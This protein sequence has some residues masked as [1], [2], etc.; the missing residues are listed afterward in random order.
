MNIKNF[1]NDSLHFYANL[2]ASGE[3]L[4]M[5]ISRKDAAGGLDLYV[6][7]L[8]EKTREWSSPMNIGKDINTKGDEEA[9]FL[10][11]D[12]KTLYFSSNGYQGEGEQD[13]YYSKRLDESWKKWSKPQNLGKDINTK[14]N[15]HGF[16]LNALGDSA[17]IVS[18]D[19]V[20]K[21]K[22]LYWICLPNEFQTEPY[23]ILSGKINIEDNEGKIKNVKI[24]VN[25]NPEQNIRIGKMKNYAIV[26]P[27]KKNYK[28]R[29]ET[30]EHGNISYNLDL[31]NV[32]QTQIIRQDFTFH[33]EENLNDKILIYFDTDSYEL[34]EESI[35]I[36]NG[37]ITAIPKNKIIKI[38][39][40]T[41]DTGSD[42]YNM[43]LSM[44]RAKQVRE[45][46]VNKGLKT[47]NILI[48]ALGEK[49]P[50]SED[51]SLNRRV[52][53]LFK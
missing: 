45:Y 2:S 46:L 39:G 37:I 16:C 42:D 29:F 13:L 14:F 11:Y 35:K 52:E 19:T 8:N 50:I 10:A 30:E 22:G 48:H 26:L 12:N 25:D 47:K 43:I 28:I 32:N 31:K 5:S 7:F 36:L 9:P 3:I 23:I 1:Y 49:E 21:R 33:R 6:S 41:D 20:S 38:F 44:K 51:N 24:I 27:V 18:Y 17:I 53:I 34:N 4:I 40:Y 15:E